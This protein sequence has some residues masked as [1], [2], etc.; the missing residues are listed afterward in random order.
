MP[1]GLADPRPL[2]SRAPLHDTS[3]PIFPSR[4]RRCASLAGSK[5]FTR[6]HYAWRGHSASRAG[7]PNPTL[8]PEG[9]A[10]TSL[11]VARPCLAGCRAASAI[12]QGVSRPWPKP[13]RPALPRLPIGVAENPRDHA[14]WGRP[15]TRLCLRLG[16]WLLPLSA[17]GG[18]S[19]PAVRQRE[20]RGG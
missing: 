14:P 12:G 8:S 20:L 19:C 9:A 10:L 16:A 17:R 2:D 3:M 15:G 11:A 13:Q 18:G 7:L 5:H 4:Y 6:Q 1:T